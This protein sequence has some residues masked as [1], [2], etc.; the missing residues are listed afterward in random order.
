MSNAL[1]FKDMYQKD[2]DN[3]SNVIYRVEDHKMFI[4]VIDKQH[5]IGCAKYFSSIKKRD[6]FVTKQKDHL[7]RITEN[8]A[9]NM[10][11]YWKNDIQ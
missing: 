7:I 8:E 5:P 9:N 3:K 4:E 2:D 10:I 11:E 6:E 1:Y